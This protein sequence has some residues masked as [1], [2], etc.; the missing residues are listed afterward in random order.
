MTSG[1]PQPLGLKDFA[2]VAAVV[3]AAFAAYLPS[4]S[5]Q[6]IWNDSDYVTSP[7]LRS[8]RGLW[9]IWTQMGATQQYYPLLHSFFWAQHRLWGDAPLG[10]HIVTVILHSASAVLLALV[11]RSLLAGSDAS[12]SLAGFE[13][14]AAFLFV[15]HPVNVESVA[16]ISEQKNTLSLALYLASAL[17]FLAYDRCR[18]A[19]AYWTA[20]SLFALSLLCKTVTATLPAAL[21][22]A[23][24]WKRG[25]LEWRRDVRPLIP[26]LAAGIAAGLF[27]SWVER[28]FVGA[29]G[30]DFKVSALGRLL[31]AG[32]ATWWYATTLSWPFGLNF[33]Y[34]KW[35]LDP[36]QVAQ[37]LF[38]LGAAAVGAVL[39]AI[40]GRARAPLA[41][42]LFFIGSLFPALGFVNLYGAR[43]SWVWDHWQYLPDIGPISLAAA[44]L[45]LAWEKL[46]DAFRWLAP[47]GS[48]VLL[49]G[50]GSLTW[51][52]CA[53]FRDNESLYL[54]TID[55]NPGSWMAHNNLGLLWSKLP[56][57][58]DDAIAQY[59]EALRL[60]PDV[61]ETHT[62]LGKLWAAMPDHLGAAI[63]EFREA[64]RIDP[65][66]SDAHFY[67]GNV[68]VQSGDLAGSIPE[69][70]AAL[71][72]DPGL[73]EASNNLGMVLCRQGHI[74]EG[75]ARIEAAL[76]IAP[77]FLQAHFARGAALLQ[78][79]RKR[80][81]AA[82]FRA[83]IALNPGF[84][85]AEQMLRIA[86][87][88][89]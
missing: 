61:A 57:R 55:R 35:G 7:S 53:M 81:A 84:T 85:P 43:Y 1:K 83:V 6:L 40:R 73:A 5:G 50:L 64:L 28:N 17:A 9:R 78:L 79:G 86:T 11:L 15:L 26:W 18:S 44:G 87:S 62:N 70:V 47:A 89:P 46:P 42:Y 30:G 68:L 49:L 59:Q 14:L 77:N 13:W 23:M 39:W 65:G 80:E 63:G 60:K 38:P 21:L 67:L 33:I 10:Y 27:T 88:G 20:T 45:Y 29:E 4:F 16:W 36:S 75:L 66:Y 72:S 22:V 34:P 58:T 54:Q 19:S 2:A 32:R 41:A 74:P 37:W 8:V 25:R 48:A 12:R 56:G 51:E 76:R 69:F 52:H 31:V 3:I 24:W 71:K 82:E